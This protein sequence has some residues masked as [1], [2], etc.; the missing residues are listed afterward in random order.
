VTVEAGDTGDGGR[1]MMA[2]A[3]GEAEDQPRRCLLNTL[4][5]VEGRKA[6]ARKRLLGRRKF[7]GKGRRE[8]LILYP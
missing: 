5:D 1:S 2:M 3:E 4:V 7:V 6:V 8:E